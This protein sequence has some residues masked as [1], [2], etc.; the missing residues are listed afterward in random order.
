MRNETI[1]DMLVLLALA[2]IGSGLWLAFGLPAALV[3]LGTVLLVFSLVV[4]G[5][6]RSEP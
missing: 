3:F 6:R 1:I 2:M 5:I 4:A